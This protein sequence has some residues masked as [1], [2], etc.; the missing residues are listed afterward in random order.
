MKKCKPE[1]VNMKKTK[2]FLSSST[3]DDLEF[4]NEA[5]IIPI[6]NH[7]T[8]NCKNCPSKEDKTYESK[9]K[10]SKGV[11]KQVSGSYSKF[12]TPLNLKYLGKRVAS[13]KKTYVEMSDQKHTTEFVMSKTS[14]FL[15]RST[16][17]RRPDGYWRPIL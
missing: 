6:S 10:L 2:Y 16:E 9:A 13:E 5:Q 1:N 8:N 4:D 14:A 11:I 12:R 7:T 17:Y 3:E 15:V